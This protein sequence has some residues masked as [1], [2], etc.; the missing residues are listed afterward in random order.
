MRCSPPTC[1]RGCAQLAGGAYRGVDWQLLCAFACCACCYGV[2][3]ASVQPA[4]M[5]CCEL[6]RAGVPAVSYLQS[7]EHQSCL[8]C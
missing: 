7:P 1:L 4:G 3:T 6:L 8:T 5:C 2:H